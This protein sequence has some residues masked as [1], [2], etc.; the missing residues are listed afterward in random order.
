MVGGRA[1]RARLPEGE[2]RVRFSDVF[3]DDLVADPIATVASLYERVGL[4]FTTPAERAMRAWSDEHPQHKHGAMPYTLEE[5]GLSRD[6]VRDAFRD[7][8]QHFDLRLEA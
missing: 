8:T 1:A 7:Y 6:Q 2:R 5:F 3:M 4:P